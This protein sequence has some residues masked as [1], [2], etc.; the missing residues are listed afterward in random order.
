MS[1]PTFT[2]TTTGFST[3]IVNNNL[4][5]ILPPSA[6]HYLCYVNSVNYNYPP[7][8]QTAGVQPANQLNSPCLTQFIKDG[9]S[10][11]YYDSNGNPVSVPAITGTSWGL[12]NTLFPNGF[13]VISLEET[14]SEPNASINYRI[15]NN[16]TNTYYMNIPNFAAVLLYNNPNYPQFTASYGVYDMDGNQIS[17]NPI[18]GVPGYK[19]NIVNN[20]SA[21][22]PIGGYIHFQI[23]R[24]TFQANL[25][26]YLLVSFT[27]VKYVQPSMSFITPTTI[28]YDYENQ[29]QPITVSLTTNINQDTFTGAS[30]RFAISNG[31]TTQNINA[32]VTSNNTASLVLT[33]GQL[34]LG[35]YTITGYYN[36]SANY[37][38]YSSTVSIQQV[39]LSITSHTTAI[40]T[41]L[42]NLTTPSS[43]FSTKFTDTCKVTVTVN[44]P[45]YIPGY[46]SLILWPTTSQYPYYINATINSTP[47]SNVYTFQ[48]VPKNIGG[49]NVGSTNSYTIITRFY[50]TSSNY[51]PSNG[52]SIPFYI[53]PI[54]MVMVPFTNTNVPYE[55]SITFE[56]YPATNGVYGD[57][58]LASIV[59]GTVTFNISDSTHHL[60]STVTSTFTN[61]YQSYL[62]I[63]DNPS[64]SIGT[65][66]VVA[67][68]TSPHVAG[69]QGNGTPTVTSSAP[70]TFTVIQQETSLTT[71]KTA[72]S[73]SFDLPFTISGTLSG[74][75]YAGVTGTFS[76][77]SVVEGV[78]T[79][80]DT[81][82]YSQVVTGNNQV[83]FTITSPQ[84]IGVANGTS[85]TFNV[86]W[87]N[88]NGDF[89][90]AISPLIT[91]TAIPDTVV[92]S[93]VVT[94]A[95]TSISVEDTFSFTISVVSSNSPVGSAVYNEGQLQMYYITPGQSSVQ[96]IGSP[97][98]ITTGTAVFPF[99]PIHYSGLPG[100]YQ[101]Y[102]TYQV[103]A[104]PTTFTPNAGFTLSTTQTV[105]INVAKAQTTITNF[106]LNDA[107][108]LASLS[109]IDISEKTVAEL[110]IT[111]LAGNIIPGTVSFQYYVN[112][113]WSNFLMDIGSPFSI[114]GNGQLTT[115]S[116]TFLQ[117]HINIGAIQVKASFVPTD[118]SRYYTTNLS[119]PFTIT[120]SLST[121]SFATLTFTNVNPSYMEALTLNVSILP[122]VNGE[123]AYIPLSGS[124]A[125]ANGATSLAT[126]NVTFTNA[127]VVS[128]VSSTPL[129]FGLNASATPYTITGTFTPSG[130]Y[131]NY[132]SITTTFSIIVKSQQV[133]LVLTAPSSLMYGQSIPVGVSATAFSTNAVINGTITIVASGQTIG[134]SS[135]TNATS[136]T[137][138]STL[139]G[140]TLQVSSPSTSYTLTATFTSNDTNY[141]STLNGVTT[142]TIVITIATVSLSTLTLDGTTATLDSEYYNNGINKYVNGNL[143]VSGHLSS[144]YTSVS[145]GTLLIQSTYIH[146]G[147]N[148]TVT[149]ITINVNADG[150]FSETVS[151]NSSGIYNEGIFYF[152]Y[153]NTNGFANTNFIT[154]T[155]TPGEFYMTI[156]TLPYMITMSQTNN[157]YVDYQ[158]GVFTCT[159]VM[160]TAISSVSRTFAQANNSGNITFQLLQN[161]N[162]VPTVIYSHTVNNNE[163]V[164][165]EEDDTTKATWTFNAKN[166]N[167]IVGTYLLSSYFTGIDGYYDSQDAY[168]NGSSFINFSI[169]QTI[170][171][172]NL[173]VSMMANAASITSA[174]YKQQPY[175]NVKVETP[176]TINKPYVSTSDILGTISFYT[177]GVTTGT[178]DLNLVNSYDPNNNHGS[179]AAN[180][181]TNIINTKN[182]QIPILTADSYTILCLFQPS[183]AVNFSSN[184]SS[185]SLLINPY[186]PVITSESVQVLTQIPPASNLLYPGSSLAEGL[187]NYDESFTIT[188][189]M[190]RYDNGGIDYSGIDG[191][192]RYSY[193]AIPSTGGPV[194][195]GDISCAA[196]TLL[197]HG[198][199]YTFIFQN[200]I[201]TTVGISNQSSD[202]ISGTMVIYPNG[203]VATLGPQGLT[204]I[205]CNESSVKL[206]VKLKSSGLAAIRVQA[207]SSAFQF[208]INGTEN[209]YYYSHPSDIP[210]SSIL[211]Y[212]GLVP[213]VY[214]LTL[215]NQ[216]D[217]IIQTDNDINW[218]ATVNPNK[219][220]QS[221]G[222]SYAL[223]L[224][225][226]PTDQVNY[227]NSL[228]ATTS[229]AVYIANAFGSLA[230]SVPVSPVS[231]NSSA[232]IRI[233][234][235]AQFVSTV[236]QSQQNGKL[237][238]FNGPIANNIQLSNKHVDGPGVS[239]GML[240]NNLLTAAYNPY[241][242]YAILDADSIDYPTIVQN[243]PQPVQVN[244]T[245]TL[246]SV[247]DFD[248]TINSNFTATLTTGNA[249]Y[250][251]GTV[252]FTFTNTA[253]NTVKCTYSM[254]FTNDVATFGSTSATSSNN[255]LI[256]TDLVIGTYRLSCA[257]TFT[258]G[259]Y[260]NIPGNNSVTF[261]VKVL[262]IPFSISIDDSNIYYKEMKPTLTSTFV[263]DVYGG[264]MTYTIASTLSPTVIYKTYTVTFDN[265]N[266]TQSQIYSYQIPDDLVVGKYV[267]TA[268]Y[269][270]SNYGI[271]VSRNSINFVINKNNVTINPL[272]VNYIFSGPFTL[273][274]SLSV[275]NGDTL[276]DSSITFV[277]M[278][279][280]Y[281]TST[282]NA[283]Y[284]AGT[285]NY[286]TPSISVYTAG[287][288]EVYVYFNGNANYNASSFAYTHVIIQNSY[289]YNPTLLS[290]SA[291]TANQT[292]PLNVVTQLTDVVFV[293]TE[294]QS[295]QIAS[296]G[297]NT[298][299]VYQLPV[300]Q[301]KTGINN[302]Y[303]KVVSANYT[304]LSNTI[305]VTV[306]QINVTS[307][308]VTCNQPDTVPYLTSVIYYATLTFDLPNVSMSEGLVEFFVNGATV[309]TAQVSG[310]VAL[311][312]LTVYNMDGMTVT[313]KYLSTLNYN[314]NDQVGSFVTTVTKAKPV[315]TISDR[316][317][318][319][320]SFGQQKQIV[321]TVTSND[322]TIYSG[323]LTIYNSGNVLFDHV[324][325]SGS[326]ATVY[327]LLEQ[328]S[329]LL[330]AMFNGNDNYIA[331]DISSYL[332]L[333]ISSAA[334]S[335]AYSGLIYTFTILQGVITATGTVTATATGYLPLNTGYIAFALNGVVVNSYI[336]NGVARANF[337]STSANDIPTATYYN[338]QYS[339]SIT[340]SDPELAHDFIGATLDPN[341]TYRVSFVNGQASYSYLTIFAAPT[342][343][344][345]WQGSVGAGYSTHGTFVLTPDILQRN[346]AI[347]YTY[348]PF[349]AVQ[350]LEGVISVYTIPRAGAY[351]TSRWSP[352]IYIRNVTYTTS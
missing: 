129:L 210:A 340:G 78:S 112:S 6:P 155:P 348:G 221:E 116:F 345:L 346:N 248:Y 147:V 244:P 239:F 19:Y 161:Q 25:N 229:F 245:L 185:V 316:S 300:S 182:V 234:Y 178:N 118:L 263:S 264:E 45:N 114:N 296:F 98:F 211:V 224:T 209:P 164:V 218:T 191:N 149:Y 1:S 208:G 145:S 57:R 160:D 163:L 154:S 269:N 321:Y 323:Y 158:D 199:T 100:S 243:T 214:P 76:L 203:Y 275:P 69:I 33:N 341:T 117:E 105:T 314:S 313:A 126:Y 165:S 212:S 288:Y 325:V 272:S 194:L 290:A 49:I 287:T 58:T 83:V 331:S 177:Q 120:T 249:A 297:G 286:V 41:T 254:P 153:N 289:A 237:T 241:Y 193:T 319:N 91:V 157:G 246:S 132:A 138:P 84:D 106:T 350:S 22:I 330:T 174:I 266:T 294:F 34:A 52:V 68:M 317:T 71:T 326:T 119:K 113:I 40:T 205:T 152:V 60:V 64:L 63:S 261:T 207:S 278:N 216:L 225:F 201:G 141:S 31:T 311:F 86:K 23:K 256:S 268:S 62:T 228:V 14:S 42:T 146:N 349:Y 240:P 115:P 304:Y 320:N 299:G 24:T 258:D 46:V 77:N 110:T 180:T 259:T 2:V 130:I 54:Q 342:T 318:G 280:G 257:V 111:T 13:S 81:T 352:Q 271:Y 70:Q 206:V 36:S 307:V 188:N 97:I 306:P 351:T 56:A 223:S 339:G 186:T 37:P 285:G 327:L 35:N 140:T 121:L 276:T 232:S 5:A 162:G 303:V 338:D 55:G 20:I 95:N 27:G 50:P 184:S 267:V 82:H 219:I 142:T 135:I 44:S 102:A 196:N 9:I 16:S 80:V 309:G 284:F 195:L 10:F 151:I 301:L 75:S 12:Y 109:S 94:N 273:S 200:M 72:I 202:S 74:V 107:S 144:P 217:S 252:L 8:P 315:V 197:N 279:A 347:V 99:Q 137:I 332:Y 172:I 179:V 247:P 103:G 183:D 265:T 90:T 235:D 171:A 67:V 39:N 21:S 198:Q 215:G 51:N 156:Q 291:I 66:T 343:E 250:T 236:S 89:A 322:S 310:N 92:T 220:D 336:I 334:I 17:I 108:T 295:F 18:N 59:L 181:I 238:F 143:I 73:T 168:S 101:F 29:S 213:N 283:T 96:S 328:P 167:F 93:L 251:G 329:Y 262:T 88:S 122:F 204:Y 189:T 293:F 85:A 28:S 226:V 190:Q 253:D 175:L 133:S 7:Q 150:T 30:V 176:A 125:I 104:D 123:G 159:T 312:H 148:T 47:N 87:V 48:F 192:M 282:W 281:N 166:S 3:D 43:P 227:T 231:Y 308:T 134:T 139:V 61:D 270:N 277:F 131:S 292:V 242:I 170:P 305:Q 173:S 53:S 4:S 136:I 233:N 38:N 128:I 302:I 337:V 255:I 65:Y 11:I 324:P 187:I 169:N 298:L 124:L 26:V 127:N 32:I 222:G 230:L 15:Y 79:P 344:I 333:N 335:T 260:Q 274:A